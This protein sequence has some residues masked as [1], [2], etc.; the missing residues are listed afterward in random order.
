MIHETNHHTPVHSSGYTADGN[1]SSDPFASNGAAL[2]FM[3]EIK[4]GSHLACNS[5][6]SK[7]ICIC[8][9]DFG[10]HTGI[11]RAALVLVGLER[12]QAIGCMVGA[13]SWKGWNHHLRN[14]KAETIDIGLHLDFTESPFLTGSRRSLQSLVTSSFLHRLHAGAVRAEIRAQLDAFEQSMDRR[15]AFV[16]GHEHIHQF[17]VIRNV[18]LEELGRRYSNLR[19]WLRS[20]RRGQTIANTPMKQWLEVLKPLAIELLGS[21]GLA[22]LAGHRGFSQNRHLLGVYDFQGNRQRYMALMVEW[23]RSASNADLLM[24]HPSLGT[25]EYDP[26]L[27]ARYNEY[28]VL[29]SPEFDQLLYYSDIALLPMSQIIWQAKAA[30]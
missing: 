25:S 5:R 22:T 19:P 2:P 20:T 3:R 13:V 24:S 12:V 21:R 10:L 30:D 29:S 16:D 14:L 9:D 11:N 6:R 1:E 28:R 23:L 8:V 27:D 15:P 26:H 4:P 17:P 18:L 7:S